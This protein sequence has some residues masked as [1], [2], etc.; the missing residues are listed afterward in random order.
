[1]AVCREIS[2]PG[3][4]TLDHARKEVLNAIWKHYLVKKIISKELAVE[5]HDAFEKLVDGKVLLIEGE[6]KYIGK[7][8]EIAMNHHLPLYDSLYVSQALRWGKLLTSDSLQ[9][10][11]SQ[12]MGIDVIYL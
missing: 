9:K 1:L 5:L 3:G 8:F 12:N 6:E 10:E 4:V 7:A 11:V 2:S